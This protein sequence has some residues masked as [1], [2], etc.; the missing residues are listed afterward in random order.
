MNRIIKLFFLS[1][2]E[3]SIMVEICFC[4]FNLNGQGELFDGF[5]IVSFSVK[6]DAFVI[7]GVCVIW[8]NL[9]SLRIISDGLIKFA[10]F[11]I[12]KTTIE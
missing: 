4:R 9:Y 6:A 7:I 10:N 3:A 1:V 8:V 11:V 12:S 2:G 5:V